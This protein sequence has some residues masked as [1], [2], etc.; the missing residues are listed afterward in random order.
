MKDEYSVQMLAEDVRENSISYIY[1]QAC[2]TPELYDLES[3]SDDPYREFDYIRT[4]NNIQERDRKTISMARKE[5]VDRRNSDRREINIGRRNKNLTGNY[6]VLSVGSVTEKQYEEVE[7]KK[8]PKTIAEKLFRDPGTKTERREAGE[9]HKKLS[10]FDEDLGYDD[11]YFIR[12]TMNGE[13]IE[14]IYDEV[15]RPAHNP[16]IGILTDKKTAKKT[17]SYIKQNSNE[18]HNFIENLFPEEENPRAHENFIQNTKRLGAICFHNSDSGKY[19]LENALEDNYL[20]EEMKEEK[21]RLKENSVFKE[22]LDNLAFSCRGGRTR[23]IKIKDLVDKLGEERVIKEFPKALELRKTGK[24]IK[25]QVDPSYFESHLYRGVCG[26]EDGRGKL[27][28]EKSTSDEI[29]E[30]YVESGEVTTNGRGNDYGR[31]LATT[32][33]PAVA[34]GGDRK[35][36]YSSPKGHVLVLSKDEEADKYVE[37]VVEQLDEVIIESEV[38]FSRVEKIYLNKEHADNLKDIEELDG[39][40]VPHPWNTR[41]EFRKNGIPEIMVMTKD[42]DERLYEPRYNDEEEW[43]EAVE[44]AKDLVVYG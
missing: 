19:E 27:Y 31:S 28:S 18:Y 35:G 34:F 10:E 37:E 15:R 9:R 32:D 16:D 25:A 39:K 23:G 41:T 29:I 33:N 12:M 6:E 4:G 40:L 26:P 20:T 14:Q 11:A 13:Y 24:G 22:Y 21:E 30:G 38:P 44:N 8:E 36:A 43:E 3:D 5:I 2:G 42:T 17:A 1:A 7:V